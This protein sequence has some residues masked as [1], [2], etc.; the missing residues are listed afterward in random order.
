MEV[1]SN[2]LKNVHSIEVLKSYIKCRNT[3]NKRPPHPKGQKFNKRPLSRGG[4]KSSQVSFYTCTCE[5]CY[6]AYKRIKEREN[7]NTKF[8]LV[9]TIS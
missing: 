3:S 8:V 9:R 4:V 5:R 7:I 1:S 2:Y 6:R